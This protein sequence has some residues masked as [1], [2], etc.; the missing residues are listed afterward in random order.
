M[1]NKTLQKLFDWMYENVIK[2]PEDRQPQPYF[3]HALTEIESFGKY[4]KNHVCPKCSQKEGFSLL[5]YERG[6]KGWTLTVKCNCGFAGI[7][8]ATGFQF[9]ETR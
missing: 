2:F 9:K 6:P 7:V 5:G 1:V 8:D 3:S 4:A